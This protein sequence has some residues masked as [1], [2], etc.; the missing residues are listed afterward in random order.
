MDTRFEAYGEP[1]PTL[2][3]ALASSYSLSSAQREALW[4][5][6]GA[7]RPPAVC[8][9]PSATRTRSFSAIKMAG[10][11]LAGVSGGV[12]LPTKGSAAL[13]ASKALFVLR[14]QRAPEPRSSDAAWRPMRNYS[15]RYRGATA[16][17]WHL[18][19]DEDE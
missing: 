15:T 9:T 1:F 3:F 6:H 19:F 14:V 12:P 17:E 2:S 13:T 8:A 11:G 16:N 5:E 10:A 7:L 4:R 18:I